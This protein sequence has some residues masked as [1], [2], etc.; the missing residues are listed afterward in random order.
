MIFQDIIAK[1]T[2][3]VNLILVAAWASFHS[4]GPSASISKSEFNILILTK[5]LETV[6]TIFTVFDKRLDTIL[7]NLILVAT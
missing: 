6:D 1:D 3:L 2:L 5:F 7:V 4:E